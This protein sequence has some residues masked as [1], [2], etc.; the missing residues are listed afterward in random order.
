MADARV[1]RYRTVQL[2]SRFFDRARAESTMTALVAE[3]RAELEAQGHTDVAIARSVEMRYL[4]QNYELEIPVAVDA[5]GEAE[6]A[7]LLQA[8]HN[9]HAARFGFRLEDH[10]EIVNFLVTG[11]ARTGTLSLPELPPAQGPAVPRGRRP[12]WFGSGFVDTPVYSRPDLGA[13]HRIDGP[14][15]VEESASV[16]VL[17]TGRCLTVDRYGNLLVAAL[18]A[19]AAA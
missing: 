13:G 15:V 12:V 3:C 2:N 5:F 11:V 1:D 6:V 18:G 14:A 8:F 9:G 17:D 16:T 7:A 4:G 10:M 19:P